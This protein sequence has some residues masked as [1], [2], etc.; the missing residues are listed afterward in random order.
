MLISRLTKPHWLPLSPC[1]E[2]V[3]L[4]RML[5]YDKRLS[6][7]RS[8]SCNYSHDLKSFG[9][10]GAATSTG[11][12][13]QMGGRSAPTVYN[14]ALH[15]AQLWDGRAADV[16]AR[17]VG[18]ILNPIEMGMPDEEFVL[19]VLNSIPGYVSAFRAAFSD[20]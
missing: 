10:D 7:D 17:A 19:K 14:A 5:Y 11:I 15:I 8:V 3:D 12:R 16:E 13:N 1:K 2:K 6:Y 9:D 20:Q 4:G 18:P